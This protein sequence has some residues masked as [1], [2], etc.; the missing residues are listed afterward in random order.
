MVIVVVVAAV[1]AAVVEVVQ[2]I[3]LVADLSSVASLRVA[4][5]LGNCQLWRHHLP[6]SSCVRR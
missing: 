1:V 5:D 6:I 4:F 3:H 2:K